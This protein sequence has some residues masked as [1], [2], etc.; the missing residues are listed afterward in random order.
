MPPLEAQIETFVSFER[1]KNVTKQ[2]RAGFPP[3]CADTARRPKTALQQILE[4]SCRRMGGRVSGV[5]VGLRG[6]LLSSGLL[7]RRD[8][9]E[10]F[11]TRDFC[12]DSRRP[13]VDTV[14]TLLYSEA[15]IL[16]DCMEAD[17]YGS[18]PFV[19]CLIESFV[20]RR[21]CWHR[22]HD[23]SHEGGL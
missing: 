13:T 12:D 19:V 17:C 5:G 22:S 18:E 10:G 1:F 4:T 21:K 9:R 3:V 14:Y 2:L 11:H 16:R 20:R 15:K 6:S 23:L 7:C 8:R